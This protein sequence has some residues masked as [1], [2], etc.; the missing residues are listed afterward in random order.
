MAK[1]TS[2]INIAL[3][4]PM[5]IENINKPISIYELVFDAFEND[6]VNEI[7]TNDK[8]LR[9]Y[10]DSELKDIDKSRY[11]YYIDAVCSRIRHYIEKAIEDNNDRLFTIDNTK[12]QGP[13]G[14]SFVLS[15]ICKID[16]N[17]IKELI[18]SMNK[19]N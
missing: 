13:Y 18:S 6:K 10:W 3:R 11:V 12:L 5:H 17:Y 14:V 16:I 1:A 9:E 4:I 19:S 7:L 2:E 8:T 15:T